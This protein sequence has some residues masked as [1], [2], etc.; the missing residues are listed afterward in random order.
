MNKSGEARILEKI[1]SGKARVILDQGGA[2]VFEFNKVYPIKYFFIGKNFI[3]LSSEPYYITISVHEF[4]G[5]HIVNGQA[6]L[7]IRKGIFRLWSKIDIVQREKIIGEI[8]NR[9]VLE[10]NIR[11]KLLDTPYEEIIVKTIDKKVLLD[12]LG[13]GNALV[14]IGRTSIVNT[15]FPFRFFKKLV[16][17][18]ME[19]MDKLVK[20]LYR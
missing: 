12:K 6:R 5:N 18:N 19:F 16:F 15:L 7:R 8:I 14:I 10:N 11:S 13:S 3:G 4:S 1:L 2:V 9:L 17:F 20:N